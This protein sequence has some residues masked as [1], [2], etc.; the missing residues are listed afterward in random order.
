MRNDI[1]LAWCAGF[2]DG[3]GNF[4]AY[5]G[6]RIVAQAAQTTRE[7]LARL[8]ATLGGSVN[9]PYA[10]TTGYG[11]KPYYTWTITN[12]A[13]FKRA[14]MSLVDHLST[15]KREQ[16]LNALGKYHEFRALRAEMSVA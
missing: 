13:G 9:G 8:Q 12:I 16:A 10:N 15:A 5:R 4:S 14:V 2:L 6:G 3:E 11:R 7:E 1:E